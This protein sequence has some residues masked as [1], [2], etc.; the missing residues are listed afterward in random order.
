MWGGRYTIYLVFVR[1]CNQGEGVWV[2]RE[3]GQREEEVERGL[4]TKWP[5][6]RNEVGLVCSKKHVEGLENLTVTGAGEAI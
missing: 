3:K 5:D 1:D 6:L 2:S 4:K